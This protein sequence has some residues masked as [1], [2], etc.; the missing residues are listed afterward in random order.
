MKKKLVKEEEKYVFLQLVSKNE[1]VQ[2]EKYCPTSSQHFLN[3]CFAC[4]SSGL[5]IEFQKL[6]TLMVYVCIVTNAILTKVSF[7]LVKKPCVCLENMVYGSKQIILK[8]TIM[9]VK[10]PNF[11]Q[12]PQ[13]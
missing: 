11:S 1:G 8:M 10:M 13:E 7:V 3:G 4:F 2:A 6:S 9:E 12:E 5:W